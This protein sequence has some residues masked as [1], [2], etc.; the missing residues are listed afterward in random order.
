[1][2]ATAVGV[3]VITGTVGAVDALV[4][5]AADSTATAVD[6]GGEVGGRVSLVF[7]TITGAG[8]AGA[9]VGVGAAWVGTGST[10]C[11]TTGAG[12]TTGEAGFSGTTTTGELGGGTGSG[13]ATRMGGAGG[14]DGGL[15]SEAGGV[16]AFSSVGSAAGTATTEPS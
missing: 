13:A 3:P 16:T 12:E 11:M 8:E 2:A 15:G 5:G 4:D 14:G 9:G 10:C 7:S 1:M 6:A